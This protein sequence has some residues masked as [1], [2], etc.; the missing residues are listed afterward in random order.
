MKRKQIEFWSATLLL[1]LISTLIV[2]S[3]SWGLGSGY[4]N[5]T[6]IFMNI[7]FRYSY[8]FNYFL[9]Q[10]IAPLLYYAGFIF[11][12]FYLYPRF[13]LTKK[14]DLFIGFLIGVTGA[15]WLLFSLVFY[16][17]EV[18][19]LHYPDAGRN[20]FHFLKDG[21]APAFIFDLLILLYL[22][23]RDYLVPRIRK[24]KEK[25]TR[26]QIILRRGRL[27]LF[28]WIALMVISIFMDRDGRRFMLF[29][30][31][32][33]A[34]VAFLCY[35]ANYFWLIP[36]YEHKKRRF[37]KYFLLTMV[38]SFLISFPWFMVFLA[39]AHAHGDDASGIYFTFWLILVLVVAPLTWLIYRRTKEQTDVLVNLQSA[40]S[41]STANI[42]FLRSQINPHFLF[43]A[44]NTL[45]GTAIQE[46]SDRT[47]QGIQKLGDMMR[48]ML[49]ENIS[50]KIPLFKEIQYLKDYIDIQK[51]RTQASD[52]I[53]IETR[54]SEACN[55][56]E[57]APM[58]LIPF[59]E[60]AFKHGIS[61]RYPS[62]IRI[63]LS[64]N[65]E[66]L[67]F[68]VTNSLHPKPENDPEKDGAG[69]GL[70]NVKQR[71][72]LLYPNQH[73]LTIRQSATEYFVH[74]TISFTHGHRRKKQ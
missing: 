58:L 70:E 12:N 17:G 4:S 47:A 11:V 40:L 54:L 33:A 39:T 35:V 3:A 43:N 41:S 27:F 30:T 66:E 5:H 44:L 68:D 1:L 28:V 23:G 26:V 65:T 25:D 21:I 38:V 49:H 34:P 64:C 56:R 42:D 61:L 60:N 13:F 15:I 37:L 19:R 52:G 69:I 72:L 53:L 29:I 32:C 9:P 8:L 46:N 63:S 24:A 73:H 57:I 50:D 22:L 2:T 62:W 48:F 31:F 74:L 20:L 55:D 71:L 16:W 45:Y 7:P 51:L 36:Y 10:L 14:F 6:L 59:V 18:Y 67:Y